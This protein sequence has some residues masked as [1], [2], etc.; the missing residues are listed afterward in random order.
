[1]VQVVQGRCHIYT[2][3]KDGDYA[4]ATRV[5]FGTDLDLTGTVIDLVLKTDEFPRD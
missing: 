4:E 3:P 5:D 2:H 1:M